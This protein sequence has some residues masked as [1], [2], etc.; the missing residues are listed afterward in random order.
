MEQVK[1]YKQ[2]GTGMELSLALI[3]T[4]TLLFGL[5]YAGNL[6]KDVDD[7]K[8]SFND[9]IFKTYHFPSYPNLT[10]LGQQRV[11]P[12]RQNYH[13]TWDAF[14]SESLPS[15]LVDYY[16]QKLGETGFT[17]EKDGGTFQFPTDSPNPERLLIISPIEAGGPH[18]S[19][20]KKPPP[21]SRSIIILSRKDPFR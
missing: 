5:G 11:Y 21:N 1:I 2:G 7:P 12:F 14:A 3:L 8:P 6:P 16:L 19:L 17:K 9:S 10:H 4:T 15:V 13:M 20:E 18:T